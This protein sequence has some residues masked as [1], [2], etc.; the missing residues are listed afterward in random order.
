MEDPAL[1]PRIASIINVFKNEFM[2]SLSNG[3]L[4]SDRFIE[5]PVKQEVTPSKTSKKKKE[6]EKTKV[7]SSEQKAKVA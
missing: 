2:E 7:S 1:A 4:E 3:T 5:E 6:K